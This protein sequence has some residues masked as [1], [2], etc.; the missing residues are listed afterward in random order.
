MESTRVSLLAAATSGSDSAWS[1]IVDLYQP[2]IFHWLRRHDVPHHDAEELTQDVMSVLVKELPIFS[3]SGRAG[4][5]RSWVRQITVNRAKGYW[6]A[7]KLRT[8]PTGTSS[9]ARMIEQLEDEKSDLS[10][11]WDQ[12][13][14]QHIL[15]RLLATMDSEF[16]PATVAAFRRQVFDEASAEQVAAELNLTIGAVYSAKS[17]VLRKLREEAAGLLG[18]CTIS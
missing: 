18:E 12:E 3:H 4:S 15:R 6:R 14:D 11:H 5:F 16:E 10:S 7:G 17:R 8:G 9:F 2:L 1:R 13:H